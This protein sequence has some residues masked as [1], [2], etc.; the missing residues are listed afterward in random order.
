M[1]QDPA[2][3]GPLS[4]D[5]ASSRWRSI[6]VVCR[7]YHRAAVS[8]P[9]VSVRPCPDFGVVSSPAEMARSMRSVLAARPVGPVRSVKRSA[10]SSPRR[11]PVSAAR[12]TIEQVLLGTMDPIDRRGAATSGGIGGLVVVG[13]GL[14]K[15]ELGGDEQGVELVLGQG[16]AWVATAGTAHQPERVVVD[17]AFVV[18]PRQAGPQGPE[19]AAAHGQAGAG[20][21]PAAQAVADLLRGQ[22]LGAAS[23]DRVG[24]QR[25][26]VRAIADVR[27]GL[28]RMIRG[29]PHLQEL[30]DGD[31][32]RRR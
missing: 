31:P 32:R 17:E 26:G 16:S 18:G 1:G 7:R 4:R 3:A 14:E 22:R 20:V 10:T 23:R 30:A 25:A 19:P 15:A 29:E 12:R 24:S 13:V 6:Q 21:L 2:A 5:S 9:R 27:R 11:A 8:A 28:P